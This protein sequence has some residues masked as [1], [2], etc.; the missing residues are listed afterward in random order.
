MNVVY[1]LIQ[2][3]PDYSAWLFFIVNIFW[4]VFVYFNKQKHEKKMAN[5]KHSLSLKFEKE[6]EI[7]E[8]EMLA[9]EITE[10]AGTYQ[11]D[12]QSDELNKKLD[13]FIKK[14]GRFRR[15]P[16]LKQAIRDLHNRCSILIYSRNKNKHKLEQDMRDQ[17]ENMHKKLITEIDKILK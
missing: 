7:T 13:D 5:L 11:L 1:E 2:K 15:Y 4:C 3:N 16:K 10:W 14:A 12:L 9:G 17:V 8:L 6:K